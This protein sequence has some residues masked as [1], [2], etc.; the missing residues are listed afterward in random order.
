MAD[1]T[2]GGLLPLCWHK[3][4]STKDPGRSKCGPGLIIGYPASL[5]TCVTWHYGHERW[6]LATALDL[7]LLI[8]RRLGRPRLLGE[9]SRGA[10]IILK[11]SAVHSFF[12]DFLSLLSV[13]LKKKKSVKFLSTEN[14][15]L[16]LQQRMIGGRS[17]CRHSLPFDDGEIKGFFQDMGV[18]HRPPVRR[19]TKEIQG[20]FFSFWLAG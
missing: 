4:T 5:M 18:E 10:D 8:G 3:F 11:G 7:A 19:S 13:A 16:S 12:K 15:V 1:L 2:W 17:G 6:W 20:W 9:T 14:F